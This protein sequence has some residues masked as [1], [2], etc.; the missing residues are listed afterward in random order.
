MG[1]YYIGRYELGDAYAT[2]SPRTG[3]VDVSNPNNPVTCKAGV[4]PYN[5]INQMDA[6]T[7]CK[8]MYKSSD[9]ES[10]LINSYVW[11][12]SIVFIQEF[13]DSNYSI[14]TG[15]N[16]NGEIQKCGESILAYNLDEGDTAQDIRCNICDMSSNLREWSTETHFRPGGPFANRG[17]GSKSTIS[18]YTCARYYEYDYKDSDY[19]FCARPILYLN[20]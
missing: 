6:S 8:N 5:Y 18:Q 11:D 4:Y 7:L 1:G 14:Q 17:G 13:E 20:L 19:V 3:T 16:N 12:T 2:E 15:I 10:D 9:F